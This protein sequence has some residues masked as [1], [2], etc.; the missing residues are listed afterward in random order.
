VAS[1][2]L[3]PGAGTDP[4]VY[5]ATIAAL[6]ALGHSGL[7]QALPL[8]DSNAGPAITPTPSPRAAR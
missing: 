2:V 5:E 7:A 1:F 4:R 6:G 8:D 3:I